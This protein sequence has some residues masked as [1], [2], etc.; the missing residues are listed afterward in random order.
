MSATGPARQAVSQARLDAMSPT[1]RAL[2]AERLAGT[3][4]GD[5]DWPAFPHPTVVGSAVPD[6][7]ANLPRTPSSHSA[8]IR[9]RRH[10]PSP[11]C[12]TS[13]SSANRR[14]KE[15]WAARGSG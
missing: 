10:R 4:Y 5:I 12:R 3:S 8:G 6:D 13:A 1:E 9:C 2:L 11:G 15:G 7:A 14:C